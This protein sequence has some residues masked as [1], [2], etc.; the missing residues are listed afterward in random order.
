MLEDHGDIYGAEPV[1][2]DGCER[3]ERWRQQGEEIQFHQHSLEEWLDVTLATRTR[4]RLD[5]CMR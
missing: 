2:C 5:T 1:L 4:M 3:I